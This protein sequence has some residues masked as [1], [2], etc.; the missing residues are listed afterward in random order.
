MAELT[1]PAIVPK[2]LWENEYSRVAA[3]PSS[4]RHE[5]AKALRLFADLLG[6][7]GPIRV[8]EA[9]CGN[10]RNAIFLAKR[11]CNVTAV[12]FSQYAVRE[13]D[14][15]AT[16]EGVRDR[17]EILE[18][19][20]D[21]PLPLADQQ[22]DAVLDAYTSCHFLKE[23]SIRSFWTEM[24]RLLKPGGQVI[25]FVFSEGDSYYAEKVTP[26]MN[27]VCDPVNGI[28]KR[29][30]TEHEIKRLLASFFELVYFTRFEFSDIVLG[31]R[32][33]RMILCVIAKRIR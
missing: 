14:R 15:R 16:L 11:G 3:I 9:G 24:H 28:S 7:Q 4:L 26:G 33:E 32:Y 20:I 29:L 19:F 1:I 12:D 22:F 25:S 13:I 17:I 30:Y 23:D 27:I 2:E 8:L 5:P 31:S 18:H 10:G 6:L 21:D